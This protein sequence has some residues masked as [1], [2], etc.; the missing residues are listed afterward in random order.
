MVHGVLKLPGCT[1]RTW[2]MVD[3]DGYANQ[4]GGGGKTC[5]LEELDDV[6]ADYWCFA[7][8]MWE[9]KTGKEAMAT[10]LTNNTREKYESDPN[11]LYRTPI[12]A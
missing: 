6:H 2:W 7:L 5:L 12:E 1:I 9:D 11:C 10:A 4:C 8:S 3:L